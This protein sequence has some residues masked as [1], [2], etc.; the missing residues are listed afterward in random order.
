VFADSVVS[1][2]LGDQW[3]EAAT[4]FRLLAPAGLVVT[5]IQGPTYWLL[6]SLGLVA[7]SL[8]ITCVYATVILVAC[9]VGVPH[10]ATGIATAYSIGLSLWVL[11]HLAWCVH[12]TPVRLAD[13]LGTVWCPLAGSAVASAIAYLAVRDIAAPLEQLVLGGVVGL[14]VYVAIVWFVFRQRA[15]YLG[16]ARDLRLMSRAG[17]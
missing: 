1:V 9:I 16:L 14:G 13:L 15:F 11:P 2:V 17:A 10:G 8:R 4:I 3:T 7:R 12:R 5:L 6:H